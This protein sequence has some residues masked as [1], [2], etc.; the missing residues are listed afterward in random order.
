[1]RRCCCSS[2][3]D[4][5]RCATRRM[6]TSVSRP[7]NRPRRSSTPPNGAQDQNNRRCWANTVNRWISGTFQTRAASLQNNQP[8]RPSS[9]RPPGGPSAGSPRAVDRVGQR[10]LQ[11][12]PP[13]HLLPLCRAG[14][15]RVPSECSPCAKANSTAGRGYA[16]VKELAILD[17][18]GRTSLASMRVWPS[19][20]RP[21]VRTVKLREIRP[22]PTAA[23]ASASRTRSNSFRG[24]C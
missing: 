11:A 17:R 8:N 21:T 24:S 19:G 22:A 3:S 20:D 12:S 23:R 15:Y 1:M 16:S 13:A 5:R 18:A 6:T 14:A 7:V 2:Y 4:L 10:E 9:R